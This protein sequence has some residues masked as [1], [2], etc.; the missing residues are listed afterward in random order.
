MV[1]AVSTTCNIP[2][3]TMTSAQLPPPLPATTSITAMTT[4]ASVA[5]TEEALDV[6]AELIP[7]TSH[8][9]IHPVNFGL[10]NN[11]AQ[12]L[13][14][15]T[16]PTEGL[17][18]SSYLAGLISVIRG[19]DETQMDINPPLV[20]LEEMSESACW[21]FMGPKGHIAVS[22]SDTIIWK[23]FTIHFPQHIHATDVKLTQAP[24]VIIM[25]ALVLKANVEVEARRF[26]TDW[27]RFVVVE[28]L[29]D[30]S[31]LNSSFAFMEVARVVYKPSEGSR[32]MFKIHS[33]VRTSIILVEILDNWGNNST[34]LHKLSFHGELDIL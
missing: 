3:V 18:S 23:Y 33:P 2:A 11:G 15:L 32:Q 19:Y 10:A 22:L 5:Q 17:G 31:V 12:V 8:S 9:D 29:L 4:I 16:S 25:R 34:C 14:A 1:E 7:L 27:E 28:Q 21:K 30:S 20:V 26:L 6:A 13:P 24:K